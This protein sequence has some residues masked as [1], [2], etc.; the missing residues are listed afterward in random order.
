MQ[1]VEATVNNEAGGVTHAGPSCATVEIIPTSTSHAAAEVGPLLRQRP[2]FLTLLLAI[3]FAFAVLGADATCIVSGRD[4]H[5]ATSWPL[6]DASEEPGCRRGRKEPAGLSRRG[7]GP[8]RRDKPA[9][10]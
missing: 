9:G 10:S 4:M 1:H 6:A 3:I 5:S 8:P 7:E 2:R